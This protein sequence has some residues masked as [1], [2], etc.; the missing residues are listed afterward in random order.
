M[1]QIRTGANLASLDLTPP[2]YSILSNPFAQ[3]QRDKRYRAAF[4]ATTTVRRNLCNPPSALFG[5]LSSIFKNL[6]ALLPRFASR[7][8]P[9]LCKFQTPVNNSQS[10][11]LIASLQVQKVT[12]LQSDL[13]LFPPCRHR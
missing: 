3:T 13:P 11:T 4:K 5:G 9:S 7:R 6:F 2:L 1:P 8:A 12:G 10:E